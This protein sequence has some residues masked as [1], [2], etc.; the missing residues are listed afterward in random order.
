MKN[1]PERLK[2]LDNIVQA[3][4]IF[5]ERCV[6]TGY[7]IERFISSDEQVHRP[8]DQGPS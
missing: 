3:A 7:Q 8:A 6:N 2:A 1:T 5:N 4:K